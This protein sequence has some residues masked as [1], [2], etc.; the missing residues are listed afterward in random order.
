MIYSVT[1]LALYL[2]SW[3]QYRHHSFASASSIGEVTSL[4]GLP[5][6]LFAD[7]IGTVAIFSQPAGVNFLPGNTLG[8]I[9]DSANNL[10]RQILIST[11]SVTVWA[12]NPSA[13]YGSTNG[14]GTNSRFRT[15]Q[16]ISISSDGSFGLITDSDNNLIR[17]V[18][19][20]TVSITRFA[21]S[22]AYGHLDGIGTSSQFNRP[23]GVCISTDGLFALVAVPYD[24]LI[25]H[26]VISTRL[27]TTLA[28][29]SDGF[30]NG[31]GSNA[32]FYGPYGVSISPDGLFAL[33]ADSYNNA[34][35][36]LV[37]STGLVSTWA[38]AQGSYGFTN[39]PGINAT[40]NNP[41]DIKISPNGLFALVADSFNRLI[42]HIVIST[43][44]VTTLAGSPGVSGSTN[45]IGTNARFFLSFGIAISS[46]NAVALVTDQ[47]Y[48]S[49]RQIF[50]DTASVNAVAGAGIS[51]GS[52]NGIGT[53]SKFNTLHGVSL[54]PDDMFALIADSNNNQI[55]HVV[56]S[57]RLVT[58][59]A[60][61]LALLSGS[62]NGIGT[63]S[64]FSSPYGVS[65]SADGLFALVADTNNHQIRHLIISTASVT[66][67]AG[68]SY[69]YVNGIG[70]NS[71]FR[72]PYGVSISPNGLFALVAD[73][74]NN[75][76]RHIDL[77][78]GSVT[79][80]AGDG[81][82]TSS[83]FYQPSG[84]TISPTSTFALV[85]DTH[86]NVICHVVISTGYVTLL[87]GDSAFSPGSTNGIGT[88][89]R[90]TFPF[91]V[92]ISADGLYGLV[93]DS[94]SNLVRR[95]VIS[96][97]SVT[98]LAGSSTGDT[99]GV[100]TYARFYSPSGVSLSA[101]GEF[102]L[103]ADTTNNQIRRVVTN[104]FTDSPTLSPS[105]SPTVSPT[106]SPTSSPTVSPTFSLSGKF[107]F[108]VLFGD[109]NILKPGEALLVDYFLSL[110]QG[111][112]PPLHLLDSADL[113]IKSLRYQSL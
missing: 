79:T 109:Q 94:N 17:H 87:A 28:G 54:S 75:A 58:V 37:I 55:R 18:V 6:G 48:Q 49:L 3:S 110:N 27:V 38:G 63:I 102:G 97:A 33:V 4:V 35:R 74:Y 1:A 67:L 101:T 100:G 95:L 59:L 39:G 105:R 2:F 78:T 80:L 30:A 16:G 56:I 68:T 77:L 60:G 42:R 92:S 73:T 31:L 9:A 91:G 103:I 69:G 83:I 70:T 81:S 107:G 15:P 96:T 112:S 7:G 34:I 62:A 53:N 86:H 65:V 76:L 50:I 113:Q 25:R 90:F 41:N 11:G 32:R 106:A 111:L 71:N 24:S 99:N 85:A 98:T 47:Y 108:G 89:S 8:L 45:G 72:L 40:F 61:D 21:G 14:I 57:T 93:G 26:I 43:V 51:S 84:V 23:Y 36:H 5:S 19:I 13:P 46:D 44:S 64:K 29:S 66:T 22:G 82:G 104:V 10:I 52:A 88:N 20:S 12:G